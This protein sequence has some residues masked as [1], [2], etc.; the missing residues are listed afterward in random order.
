MRAFIAAIMLTAALAAVS[1]DVVLGNGRVETEKRILP[2]FTSISVSGSGILR[3]HRG[4]QKVELTSD[5]NILP[6][7][8]TSVSGNELVI[9]FKPFTS[10]MHSS[11][12]QYDVT[13]PELVGLKISGSGDA[14][15]DAF[16]GDAFK[17]GISGSGG[18]KAELEYRS[19]ELSVSGSGGFDASLK[20]GRLALRCSGSGDAYLKGSADSAEL[21]I[22]GSGMLGARDFAV[23][24]ARLVISGSGRAEIRA[25][26]TLD[27]FLSGSG[28][29]SYWGDPK[30]S[31]KI[32]GSGRISR[33]GSN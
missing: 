12:M 3:V 25:T 2:A 17:A 1:A 16:K 29:I 26:R 32:S 11:K 22:T 21:A 8:T 13:L 30:L 31:Q 6:Y 9:G 14:Y 33:G 28:G 10:I 7:I 19:V 4:G 24:E 15:V 18:I 27:A 5:S 20:T 23:G